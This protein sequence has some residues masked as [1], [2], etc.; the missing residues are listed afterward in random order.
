MIKKN[1]YPIAKHTIV[2]ILL[3][4]IKNVMEDAQMVIIM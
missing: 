2:L 1:V 3:L 4:V